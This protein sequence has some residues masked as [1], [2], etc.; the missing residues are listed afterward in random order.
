MKKRKSM[1]RAKKRA[2]T[3]TAAHFAGDWWW[4]EDFYISTATGKVRWEAVSYT[5]RGGSIRL[6]RL[7]NEKFRAYR[8]YVP[9]D[10]PMRLVPKTARSITGKGKNA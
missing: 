5:N 3:G 10:T 2:I 9:L 4:D 1:P 6:M 8:A 7:D